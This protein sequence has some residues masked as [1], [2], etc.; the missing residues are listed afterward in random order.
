VGD[1]FVAG[2]FE[3]AGKGLCWLNDFG[4]HWRFNF[5]MGQGGARLPAVGKR[6]G[7]INAEAAE[8][9]KFAEER[10]DGNSNFR[11]G[12]GLDRKSVRF[13]LTLNRHCTRGQ[14]YRGTL[15]E[16]GVKD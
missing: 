9:A 6:R 15:G 10:G 1:G 11:T 7:K 4:L 2:K 14:F 5:S 8:S 3:R 12:S 16:F 13:A